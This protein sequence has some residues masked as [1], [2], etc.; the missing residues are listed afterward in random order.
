MMIHETT[1]AEARRGAVLFASMMATPRGEERRQA[2]PA[3]LWPAFDRE[4][5]VSPGDAGAATPPMAALAEPA[6]VPALTFDEGELARV[7]AA[8]AWRWLERA[9]AKLRDELEAR[10]V[11]ALE[12]AAEALVAALAERRAEEE[13]IRRQVVA[14]AEAVGRALAGA[15]GM[16]PPAE[17]QAMIGAILG[18]I[19]D[20]PAARVC[21]EAAAAEPLRARTAELAAQAGFAGSL[22][23]VADERLPAGAV[24]LTWSGG[25]AEHAPEA[26]GRQVADLLDGYRPMI[27]EDRSN[28]V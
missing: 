3:P 2:R 11:A 7:G 18:K 24:R 9:E 15:A 21:V 14:I 16:A 25:W 22:E 10:R 4:A 17:V 19:V 26:V 8:I 5:S 6:A 27:V 13:L 23:V 28:H 1:S 20:L 12:R